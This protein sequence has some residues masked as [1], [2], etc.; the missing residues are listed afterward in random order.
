MQCKRLYYEIDEIVGWY[1]QL[2]WRETYEMACKGAELF[3]KKRGLP[4]PDWQYFRI[5]L[6]LDQNDE[7]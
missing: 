6:Q 1:D 4:E 3:W 2:W 5:D 7:L